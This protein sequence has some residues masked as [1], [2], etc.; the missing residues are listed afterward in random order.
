MTLQLT[1]QLLP[2]K[3]M[4]FNT[5]LPSQRVISPNLCGVIS[6][7]YSPEPHRIH[8]LSQFFS[9]VKNCLQRTMPI[10]LQ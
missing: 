8:H 7:G 1:L 5:F 9:D 4:S 3:Q 2:L 6:M 10:E